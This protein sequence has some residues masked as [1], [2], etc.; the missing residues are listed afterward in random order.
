MTLVHLPMIIHSGA[1]TPAER[2]FIDDKFITPASALFLNRDL[3]RYGNFKDVSV[4]T[5]A[6]CHIIGRRGSRDVTVC[7]LIG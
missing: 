6:T 3:P 4:R 7:C 2:A 5:R 1:L